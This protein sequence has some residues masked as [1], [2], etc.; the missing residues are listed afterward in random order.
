ME[1]LLYCLALGLVRLLQALPLRWVAW[2]GRRAGGLACGLDR[3]HRR[4]ALENLTFALHQEKN[5]AELQDLV[6]EHFR[7]LGE[8][9][10]SAIKTASMKP[11][12][13][14]RHFEVVGAERL[15]PA[16]PGQPPPSVLFA[17]GHFGNFELYAW[18]GLFC[19]GYRLVTTYRALPQTRLNALLVSL[20]RQSGCLVF[21]RRKEARELL[22]LMR[23]PGLFVGLLSDQHAGQTGVWL[24]FFGRECS[25][26]TAPAV[27]A[28]RHR[29]PLHPA[30]CF[31]TGLAR[32]SIEVGEEIP[33]FQDGQRRPVTEVMGAVNRAFEQAIRRDP[34]NWFWVHRRWKPKP[35]LSTSA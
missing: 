3:R 33:T 9:Y 22:R 30:F 1:G 8:N 12:T 31:R 25:T 35:R 26:I 28:Q 2:L 4:V 24:P 10:A 11:E 5:P 15:P 17:I 16:P 32:W 20:R 6:R 14:A 13:L 27:L 7:R 29:M 34:A 21:E 18:A 19:R 23:Q